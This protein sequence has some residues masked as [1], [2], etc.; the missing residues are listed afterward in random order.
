ML[1]VGIKVSFIQA[2]LCACA[3]NFWNLI[4][5]AFNNCISKQKLMKIVH[6]AKEFRAFSLK[7]LSRP[8]LCSAKPRYRSAYQGLDNVRI[9][10]YTKS[11]TNVP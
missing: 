7:E 5:K 10:L 6:A 11:E 8:K 4:R 1:H 9:H 2:S 3:A